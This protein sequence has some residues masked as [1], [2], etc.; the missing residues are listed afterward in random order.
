MYSSSTVHVALP[1]WASNFESSRP[2][3]S[4]KAEDNKLGKALPEW[5]TIGIIQEPSFSQSSFPDI[6]F[7]SQQHPTF[8]SVTQPS[9]KKGTKNCQVCIIQCF[10]WSLPRSCFIVEKIRNSLGTFESLEW[11]SNVFETCKEL[12]LLLDTVNCQM[13]N[14]Y[15]G[16]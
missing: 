15:K 11:F 3:K 12:T 13:F 16:K 9:Q 2:G 5:G 10:Y 1:C 14:E 8:E 4:W 6:N 7:S